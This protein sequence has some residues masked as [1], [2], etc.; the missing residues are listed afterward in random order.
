M[1]NTIEGCDGKELCSVANLATSQ[2]NKRAGKPASGGVSIRGAT[3]DGRVVAVKINIPDSIKNEPVRGGKN[4]AQQ[5]SDHVEKD[6]CSQ[7]EIRR[8]VGLG[9]ELQFSTYLSSG[10]LFSERS[11]KSC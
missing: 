5:L 2:F 3:T 8:F 1:W 4:A 6:I 7:K 10:E 11:V 9:G